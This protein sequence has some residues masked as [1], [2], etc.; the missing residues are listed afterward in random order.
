M[1]EKEAKEAIKEIPVGSKIQLIKKNGVITEL[2]LASHEVSG[3]EK[4]DYG[5][6]VV[7][8]LPPAL[9]VRGGSRFGNF[10]LDTEEIVKIAWVEE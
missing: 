8:A 9:I 5:D 1:T 10:R 2:R 7:P 3:T 6:I 4:K